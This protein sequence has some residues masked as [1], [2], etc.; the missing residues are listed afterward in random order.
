MYRRYHQSHRDLAEGD[1]SIIASRVSYGEALGLGKLRGHSSR[2][3]SRID[4]RDQSDRLHIG[5]SPHAAYT[6][7]LPGYIE[8]LNR[9][10]QLGLPIATH[11]AENL[12]SEFP[13]RSQR[14]FP[15]SLEQARPLGRPRRNFPRLA[16]RLRKIDRPARS[17]DAARARE[18]LQRHRARPAA[19]GKASVVYCPR[20]TL[21]SAIRRIALARCSPRDE[22][23]GRDRQL[24]S[25]PDLNLVDDLRLL[26]NI[27]PDLSAEQIWPFDHPR[28]QRAWPAIPTRQP[29]AGQGR[30][31]HR[32]RNRFGKPAGANPAGAGVA[33]AFL[34]GVMRL[35]TSARYNCI[36][37][38]RLLNLLWQVPLALL[39]MLG[40]LV[41]NP[42]LA[43]G[44]RGS[45]SDCWA[46]LPCRLAIQK[47]TA[48]TGS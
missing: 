29:H 32:V 13:E 42:S 7:D 15:R 26:R 5:I 1:S 28:G 39:V 23:R 20:T 21:T 41:L 27:A 12:T 46:G 44:F 4:R 34:F 10:K 22:R 38:R 48:K 30:R 2:H 40:V 11:L 9:A 43:N 16:D 8:C 6:V 17:S 24:A 37:K 18:L 47:A 45:G 19:A 14:N 31:C 33:C 25:S 36:V 3:C 35:A